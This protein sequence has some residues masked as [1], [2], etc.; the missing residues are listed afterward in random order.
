MV[1]TFFPDTR[2]YHMKMKWIALERKINVVYTRIL[3]RTAWTN[4][5]FATQYDN[6]DSVF[7]L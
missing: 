1:G 4:S 6:I 3:C 2:Y 5:I 7:L